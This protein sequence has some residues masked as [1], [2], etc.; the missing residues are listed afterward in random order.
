MGTISSGAVVNQSIVGDRFYVGLGTANAFNLYVNSSLGSDSNIGTSAALAYRTIDHAMAQ[1]PVLSENDTF[2]INL[3]GAANHVVS[4]GFKINQFLGNK[5]FFVS[6][7]GFYSTDAPLTFRATAAPILLPGVV[8]ASQT[9]NPWS[10]LTRIAT[11][12]NVLI[13]NLTGKFVRD[14][15]GNIACIRT[16]TINTFD[17]AFAGAMTAP[18][19][20]FGTG[21]T[22]VPT[23]AGG[24]TPTALVSGGKVAFQGVFIDNTSAGDFFAGLAVDDG[25]SAVVEACHIVSYWGSLAGALN[26]SRLLALASN[27]DGGYVALGAQAK[28]Q[29]SRSVFFQN[30]FSISMSPMCEALLDQC[31]AFQT[32]TP[33]FSTGNN[34]PRSPG[35]LK[36]NNCNVE[37]AV[38]LAIMQSSGQLILSSVDVSDAGSSGVYLSDNAACAAASLG[39]TVDN[40]SFGVVAYSG[41][42]ASVGGATDIGG[43]AGDLAVGS[44]PP[45]TWAA[46]HGGPKI[47]ADFTALTGDGSRVTE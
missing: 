6:N 27:F 47:L 13:A 2:I 36:L 35:F 25:G 43:G 16:N 23:T 33:L 28:L 12:N 14:A 26:P 30:D 19:T 38:S 32:V 3:A 21:A 44:L 31:W 11:T 20:F 45:M 18:L 17:I 29:A 4:N 46:F 42:Q 15:L 8:I 5:D 34:Y 41:A 24:S 9:F 22:I 7:S 40:S 37:S 39:S 10:G 1:I